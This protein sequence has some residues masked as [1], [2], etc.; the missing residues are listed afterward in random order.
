M[1]I[2]FALL[3]GIFASSSNYCLRR[4]IDAG[5]S[6]RAYLVVQLSFSFLVMILLNPLRMHDFGWSNQVA[7]LGLFGGLILGVFMWGLGKCLEKGPPGLTLAIVNTSSIMPALVLV[8]LFGVSYGHGYTLWNGL[9]SVLVAIG[10][11]W[12]GWTSVKN[13]KWKSWTLFSTMAFIIH[14]LFLV[15]LSWWAM[16]L[17]TDLPLSR[18]L[19]FHIETAHVHWFMPSIFFMAALF[20]WGVY[21]KQERRM[22]K[23]SELLYGL[24]GGVTN[25]TCSFFLIKAPQVAT[26][27][28]NAMLF[29]I[30]SV[31]IILFCNIWSQLI[32]R[33]K[34]NWRANTLC[35]AGLII[36]TVV[37]S[38]L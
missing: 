7:T 30:F 1:G 29:P 37:W 15:Y 17:S 20:Q 8:L 33:E 23:S 35:I 22:P 21:L 26:A 19:P 10:I 6:S 9:G 25:G 12:A 4:S 24:L 28:Q 14:T 38:G 36:G 31:S 11:F 18:L 2:L 32:Y 27:W 3:A 34:V 13:E 5:G 16:V